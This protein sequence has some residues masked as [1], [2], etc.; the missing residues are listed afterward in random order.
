MTTLEIQGHLEGM[1]QVKGSPALISNVTEAVMEEMK[2]WQSR[3][4]DGV[5]PI[6]YLR[7]IRSYRI[8]YTCGLHARLNL[9]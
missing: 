7:N 2:A 5:Y 8:L 9:G 3:S 6:V 4:L 1:Y